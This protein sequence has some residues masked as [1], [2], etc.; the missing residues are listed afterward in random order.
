MHL[1]T[2]VE[3]DA[4]AD[5]LHCFEVLKYMVAFNWMMFLCVA[6]GAGLQGA[7]GV[8]CKGKLCKE[9]KWLISNQTS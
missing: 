1:R 4:G 7:G 9:D 3:A 8:F 5:T 2:H 6:G